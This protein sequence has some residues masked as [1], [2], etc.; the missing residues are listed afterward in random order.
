VFDINRR[1]FVVVRAAGPEARAALLTRTPDGEPIFREVLRAG[2]RS[3]SGDP[4]LAGGRWN[5]VGVVPALAALAGVQLGGRYLGV[6]ELANPLGGTPLHSGELNA[7]EY[8]AQQFAEFV[9]SKPL[10]LDDDAVLPKA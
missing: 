9:A 8:I 1:E 7:L 10:I 2:A 4:R 3:Y 5:R 6:L